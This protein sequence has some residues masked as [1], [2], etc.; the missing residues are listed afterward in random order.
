[1]ETDGLGCTKLQARSEL[2]FPA[3]DLESDIPSM[4]GEE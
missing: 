1:M 2:L 3:I 4:G